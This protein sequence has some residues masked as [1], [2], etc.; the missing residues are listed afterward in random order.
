MK[1]P[2]QLSLTHNNMIIGVPSSN[3]TKYYKQ[4]KRPRQLS[5]THTNMIIG[6]PSSNKKQIL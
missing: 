3:K 4:M 5:L 2:R 6:V 1:R